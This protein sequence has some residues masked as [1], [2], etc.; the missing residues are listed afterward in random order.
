MRS[1]WCLG[2]AP[3]RPVGQQRE[4][5]VEPLDELGERQRAQRH[6]R[7]LDRQRYAV[8]PPAQPDDVGHVLRGDREAGRRG[9]GAQREQLDRVPAAGQAGQVGQE[10]RPPAPAAARRED[11]LARHVERLP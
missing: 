7:Q 10:A 4:P 11:V 5:V 8:E 3:G 2:S 6:R 9:G 1:V